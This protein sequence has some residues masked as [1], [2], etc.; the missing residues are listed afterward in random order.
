M[1]QDRIAASR[2]RPHP[3]AA[4]RNPGDGAQRVPGTL[5]KPLKNKGSVIVVLR[6][7]A[8]DA[9]AGTAPAVRSRLPV[10]GRLMENGAS[11]RG[12]KPV[13]AVDHPSRPL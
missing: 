12:I 11:L 9:P 6:L 10:V 1:R 8:A 2:Y 3:L 4:A 7:A 5:C 13:L